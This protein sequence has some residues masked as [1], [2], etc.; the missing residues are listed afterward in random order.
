[1]SSASMKVARVTVIAMA[2]GLARGRH[3]SWNVA[4]AA[5]ATPRPF[6]IEDASCSRL[7]QQME[8]GEG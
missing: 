1:V 2:Q 8:L 5:A 6:G 3:V 4:V 7:G